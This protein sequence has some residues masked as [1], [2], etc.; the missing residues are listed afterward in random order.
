MKTQTTKQSQ[1]KKNPKILISFKKLKI[2][3][4]EISLNN[5]R[6]DWAVKWQLKVI[7][8][9]SGLSCT[10]NAH[11]SVPHVK[12]IAGNSE[13]TA[14]NS[15]LWGI[16]YALCSPDCAGNGFT[17]ERVGES[18]EAKINKGQWNQPCRWWMVPLRRW[19]ETHPGS[20]TTG[21]SCLLL[22]QTTQKM[23]IW[24]SCQ[25]SQPFLHH[26]HKTLILL[27]SLFLFQCLPVCLFH[28]WCSAL[29]RP[30]KKL[31]LLSNLPEILFSL[32]SASTVWTRVMSTLV[33]SVVM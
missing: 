2:F 25:F 3:S 17:E 12:A 28:C 21:T 19:K 7:T 33:M 1:I 22:K 23:D 24:M 11:L 13:A 14:N 20:G 4:G 6:S 27:F 26:C 18:W 16:I 32:P 10:I 5:M 29:N 15:D 8:G 31:L 30:M 9:F